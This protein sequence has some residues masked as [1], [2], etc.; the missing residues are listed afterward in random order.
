MTPLPPEQRQRLAVE[1]MGW[2]LEQHFPDSIQVDYW[3]DENGKRTVR[4]D[5]WHPDQYIEQA[6]MLAE[7]IGQHLEL[8]NYENGKWVCSIHKMAHPPASYRGSRVDTPA[9][10]ICLAAFAWLERKEE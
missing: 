5:D 7:K 4:V 8:V 1:V 3:A 6:F 2:H 10:A 9:L